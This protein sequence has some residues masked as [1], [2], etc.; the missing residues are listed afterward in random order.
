VLSGVP[1]LGNVVQDAKA[2]SGSN[3]NKTNDS[4]SQEELFAGNKLT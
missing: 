3:K 2:V 1:G 4:H